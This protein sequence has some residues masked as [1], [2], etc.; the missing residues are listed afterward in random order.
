[1]IASIIQSIL[2]KC[3]SSY[4]LKLFV[5]KSF[6][7]LA[8]RTDN[9]IDDH[10]VNLAGMILFSSSVQE[11]NCYIATASI[12]KL[13]QEINLSDEQQQLKTLFLTKVLKN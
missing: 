2:I 6:K 9:L 12:D 1:M 8:A 5:Y 10:I 7:K 11:I 4:T 13:L 3:L